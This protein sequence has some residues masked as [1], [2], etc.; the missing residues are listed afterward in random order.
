MICDMPLQLL[1]TV[2][3]LYPPLSSVGYVLLVEVLFNK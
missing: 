3:M 2:A 1:K